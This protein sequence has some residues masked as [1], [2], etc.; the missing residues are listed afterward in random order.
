MS[1]T[2]LKET[3][4]RFLQLLKLSIISFVSMGILVGYHGAPL[5]NSLIGV[6]W[7]VFAVASGLVVMSAL[8]RETESIEPASVSEKQFDEIE[9]AYSEKQANEKR[10]KRS[11]YRRKVSESA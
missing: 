3:S 8:S 6:F 5:I 1:K 2:K 11:D 7:F 4:R 9:F 10:R